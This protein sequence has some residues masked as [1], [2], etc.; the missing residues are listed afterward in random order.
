VYDIN[1][2]T[3]PH[4]G[5]MLRVIA[6][7]EGLLLNAEILWQVQQRE[8]L[9]GSLARPKAQPVHQEQTLSPI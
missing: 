2:E 8:E 9:N 6:C 3:C 1:V 5:A 4:G 7:I